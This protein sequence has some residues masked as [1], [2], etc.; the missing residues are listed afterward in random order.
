MPPTNNSRANAS[1]GR[2]RGRGPGRGGAQLIAHNATPASHI[3]TIGVRRPGYGTGGKPVSIWVNS[4]ETTIPEGIIHHYDDLTLAFRPNLVVISPSEKTLPARLN[5][6]LIQALQVN[7]APEIFT[8]RGVYDGRKNFFAARELPFGGA[9]FKE[10]NVSLDG[11]R[12]ESGK[13]PKV[14]KITLTKVAEI[15]PE[16][17][18]RFIAGAQSHDNTVLTAITVSRLNISIRMES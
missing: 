16:T 15:N 17:L 8:P 2:G 9:D 13:N 5:M 14:Y 7:V 12:S 4:F 10:F 18:S 1:R 11:G 3:T 6:N